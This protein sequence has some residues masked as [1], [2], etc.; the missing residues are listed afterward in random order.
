MTYNVSGHYMRDIFEDFAQ[1][2]DTR[3]NGRLKIQVSDASA[4]GIS[5]GDI[6]S[7]LQSGAL[8]AADVPAAYVAGVNKLIAI[9][10][11]PFL[12]TNAEEGALAGSI[13]APTIQA[14][15]DKYGVISLARWDYDGLPF[16]SKEPIK[17]LADFEGLRIRSAGG[18][19]AALMTSLGAVPVTMP[20]GDIYTSAQRGLL[21]AV[22][23]GWGTMVSASLYEVFDYIDPMIQTMASDYL[24][25]SKTLYDELPPDVKVI[26]LEEAATL[27]PRINLASLNSAEE[28]KNELIEN[29]MTVVPEAVDLIP[30]ITEKA[31]PVWEDWATS[32][33]TTYV[34]ALNLVKST[35]NK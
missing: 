24:F 18:E 3:T 10:Y 6:L 9:E 22:S 13:L 12:I 35:L 28:S 29:G 7:S 5:P 32:G 27:A 26:L 2:V 4:L 23:T 31:I 20:A 19:F 34:D 25:V 1:T 17:T 8:S 33:G 21:D 11:L 15:L 16:I 30:A 14:E